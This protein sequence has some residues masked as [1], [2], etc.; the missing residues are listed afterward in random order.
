[1]FTYFFPSQPRIWLILE[2]RHFSL[3]RNYFI[4]FL[5]L[6]P[7]EPLMLL[8]TYQVLR[9]GWIGYVLIGRKD[10]LLSWAVSVSGWAWPP[11]QQQL[12]LCEPC[13]GLQNIQPALQSP[14]PMRF[15]IFCL[16]SS[17]TSRSGLIVAWNP[18]VWLPLGSLF[19]ACVL[20]DTMFSH[21]TSVNLT[22]LAVAQ[23]GPL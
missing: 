11:A 6:T 18:A 14:G 22:S 10:S 17:W 13:L 8:C 16:L 23:W 12:C 3:Q 2:P 20:S 5:L 4:Y 15:S 1:M 19:Q 7:E 9:K 21:S